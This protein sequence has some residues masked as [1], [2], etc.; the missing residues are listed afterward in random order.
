MNPKNGWKFNSKNYFLTKT[1]FWRPKT[2]FFRQVALCMSIFWRGIQKTQKNPE[3]NIGSASNIRK[4]RKVKKINLS[5]FYQ[6][7]FL[8]WFHNFFAIFEQNFMTIAH[9]NH[10][11]CQNWCF[12]EK[13]LINP[14]GS[15]K[16]ENL[17]FRTP[18]CYIPKNS[19][20]FADSE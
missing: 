6:F 7:L 9:S 4:F 2:Q 8:I 13:I 18:T 3:K 1:R 19:R 11:L 20:F 14:W 5:I 10:I 16:S 17:F 12:S 15:G